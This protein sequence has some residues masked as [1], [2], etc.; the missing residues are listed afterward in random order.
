MYHVFKNKLLK[1]NKACHF[2]KWKRKSPWIQINF[3]YTISYNTI[4]LNEMNLQSMPQNS[5]CEGIKVGLHINPL[6]QRLLCTWQASAVHNGRETGCWKV[7][8]LKMSLH[9]VEYVL[10]RVMGNVQIWWQICFSFLRR[11]L[12]TALI[13]KLAVHLNQQ[14]WL[15]PELSLYSRGPQPMFSGR[16]AIIPQGGHW[17]KQSITWLRSNCFRQN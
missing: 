12:N 8:S 10:L 1:K 2:L 6:P 14:C 4:A 13:G 7:C 9:A 17:L 11:N 3:L 16:L 15:V 5:S